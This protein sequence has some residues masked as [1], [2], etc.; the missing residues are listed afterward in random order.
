MNLKEFDYKQFLLEKGERVGLAVAGSLAGLILIL[1]LFMPGK[2]FF[3]GSP[4]TKAATLEEGATKLQ[5]KLASAEPTKDDLPRGEAKDNLIPLDTKTLPPQV[6]ETTTW[7][8]PERSGSLDRRPPIVKLPVE[9]LTRVVLM[10]IDTFLFNPSHTKVVALQGKGGGNAAPAPPATGPGGKGNPM[11]GMMMGSMRQG[12]SGMMQ[13]QMRG[14]SRYKPVSDADESEFLA[15]EV[16][17]K[18][19]NSTTHCARQPR[20]LR[21]A[22]IVASF[23]YK[24]QIE[25]F[26]TKLRLSSVQDVLNE[27]VNEGEG[28]E[29]SLAFRFLGVHVQRQELDANDKVISDW[30]DVDL[31]GAYLAWQLFAYWPFEKELPKYALLEPLYPGLAMPRLREFHDEAAEHVANM[32][33]GMF[34]G[35]MAGSQAAGAKAA[36]SDDE[37]KKDTKYPDI[38]G[39]L[40]K[41]KETLEKLADVQPKQIA[42][43]SERFLRPKTIDPFNPN[44]PAPEST[45][46]GQTTKPAGE[47][48][49]VPDYCLVRVIDVTVQPGKFYRY[50]LKIRMANPNYNNPN[51]AS[52]AYKDNKE[53]ESPDWYEVKGTVSVPSELIH[54]V[55]DQKNI[56]DELSGPRGYRGMNW[57]VGVKDDQ[58]VFQIHRW[59]DST[60]LPG[61]TDK[62]DIGEWAVA[63]R[64]PVTRG[65]YIG[66]YLKVQLPIWRYTKDAFVLA[67]PSTSKRSAA[68][69]GVEVY[70]GNENSDA[71]TI[72]VDFEGGKKWLPLPP[73]GG[74][75]VNLEDTSAQEV[76]MLSPE[77]KLLARNSAAD[78]D[79]E[80]RINRRKDYY[81]RI[82]NV[83]R[84]AQG[85][86][87][88]P[89]GGLDKK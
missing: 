58:V 65:E 51:V 73:A 53:I 20:P 24:E 69:T 89:S 43:P 70:F 72:L 17:L 28:K 38:E 37:N 27:M 62:D 36:G 46:A 21:M 29:Q 34:P 25:E 9:S 31:A 82:A 7:F 49:T 71:D 3:S 54:Y 30:K 57:N 45:E 4:A 75:P 2:G 22:M 86:S 11:A 67:S 79:D 39:E 52:S 41:I 50:R 85:Q 66:R 48:S 60:Q 26:K 8:E 19:V 42:A 18:D 55:V 1:S 44:P 35:M 64:V 13:Q 76:L 59:I 61:R 80:V 84:K 10:Q 6:Y 33:F 12:G 63:D 16:D 74:K 77:G 5:S 68:S 23:P 87:A 81:V 32:G 47:G 88:I 15:R 56:K 78:T 14:L 40:P 83:I